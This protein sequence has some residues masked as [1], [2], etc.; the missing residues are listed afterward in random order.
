MVV[1]RDEN[2]SATEI[3]ETGSISDQL[4]P[5]TTKIG[6]HSFPAWRSALKGTESVKP[7][8]CVVN[9]WEGWR[10]RNYKKFYLKLQW[11]GKELILQQLW[12]A[13]IT[14][15][16]LHVSI[17]LGS[18]LTT[19]SFICY[20]FHG[21]RDDQWKNLFKTELNK[22]SIRLDLIPDDCDN[23]WNRLVKNVA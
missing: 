9:R 1:F 6:S 7:P 22:I 21:F 11:S 19:I 10:N 2:S 5:K 20:R 3:L 13:T 23:A 17:R 12:A 18:W 14:R 15:R 8:L 4:K 16:M